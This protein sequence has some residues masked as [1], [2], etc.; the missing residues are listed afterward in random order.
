MEINLRLHWKFGMEQIMLDHGFFAVI[1]SSYPWFQ[2]LCLAFDNETNALKVMLGFRV[3]NFSHQPLDICCCIPLSS[4]IL[5]TSAIRSFL[6]LGY[7]MAVHFL[8]KDTSSASS[9]SLSILS[10]PL[11]FSCKTVLLTLSPWSRSGCLWKVQMLACPP[12]LDVNIWFRSGGHCH[13]TIC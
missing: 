3:Q 9:S 4:A 10:V 12:P 2:D 11:V 7:P 5:C 1:R 13:M 8:T 6:V